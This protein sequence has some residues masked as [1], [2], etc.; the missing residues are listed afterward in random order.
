MGMCYQLERSP[1][2]NSINKGIVLQQSQTKEMSHRNAS[3]PQTSLT[4]R[5]RMSY[6]PNLELI[7]QLGLRYGT[8]SVEH[9]F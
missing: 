3:F 4:L 7:V 2:E 5:S 9:F 6:Y 1:T 8:A